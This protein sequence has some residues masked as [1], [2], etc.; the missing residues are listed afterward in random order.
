[1]KIKSIIP[2][3]LIVVG[4]VFLI[5]GLIATPLIKSLATPE[6]LA[7]NVLLNAIP[8][9]LIF[10]SILLLYITI[11]V[12][13]GNLLNNRIPERIYKIIET[14]LIVGIVIG[15]LSMFQPWSV[16]LYKYGFIVVLISVLS[17]IIWSHTTP[18]KAVRSD[19]LADSSLIEPKQ[20]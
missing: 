11:L 12:I 9:I 7:S 13:I 6:Q 5:L 2:F 8:F 16:V 4:I 20:P 3:G 1:V 10:I 18:K 17:Y 19:E 15:V 14:V